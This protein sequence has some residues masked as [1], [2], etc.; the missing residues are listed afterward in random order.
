MFPL[1]G[2]VVLRESAEAVAQAFPHGRS[3]GNQPT[4]SSASA[5]G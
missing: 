1:D 5:R 4:T 3:L 2:P